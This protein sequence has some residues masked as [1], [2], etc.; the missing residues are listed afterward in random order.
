MQEDNASIW[1]VCT[2]D[3]ADEAIEYLGYLLS[4]IDPTKGERELDLV[5]F[6]E[7]FMDGYE[8]GLRY[9]VEKEPKRKDLEAEHSAIRKLLKELT[10][11]RLATWPEEKGLGAEEIVEKMTTL[12]E[13]DDLDEKVREELT[14]NVTEFQ[15]ELDELATENEGREACIDCT[16]R[17]NNPYECILGR[18]PKTCGS[19]TE[20]RAATIRGWE[21]SYIR[22]TLKVARTVI[23]ATDPDMALHTKEQ[24]KESLR[25]LDELDESER[26]LFKVD[27]L[28]GA[29]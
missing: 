5:Q 15:G 27:E 7:L 2:P 20:D 10:D 8:R 28:T 17:V 26:E 3:T 11:R 14:K 13:R 24:I 19:F 25:I 18:D 12:L 6:G 23:T 16:H 21:R 1:E 22:K 9:V 29:R 4:L